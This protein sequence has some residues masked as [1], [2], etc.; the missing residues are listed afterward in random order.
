MYIIPETP[1]SAYDDASC[2]S[3]N[4]ADMAPTACN[5]APYGASDPT[6]AAGYTNMQFR[7][8]PFAPNRQPLAIVDQLRAYGFGAYIS[9]SFR[10]TIVLFRVRSEKYASKSL[11]QQDASR[12]CRSRGFGKPGS[13]SL[14]IN[15]PAFL[16]SFRTG[17][18]VRSFLFLNLTN[19]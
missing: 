11:A 6:Y 18:P 2:D 10:G 15:M 5:G 14:E 13:P 17:R 12:I 4:A 3:E 19:V 9:E 8:G 7:L 16:I 1:R